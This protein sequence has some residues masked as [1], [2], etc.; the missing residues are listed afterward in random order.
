MTSRKKL[1]IGSDKNILFLKN[2]LF[3][4]VSKGLSM[5][6]LFLKGKYLEFANLNFAKSVVVL[7]T[8]FSCEDL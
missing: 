2:I 1:S 8:V 5:I 6:D 7:V 3:V 4:P